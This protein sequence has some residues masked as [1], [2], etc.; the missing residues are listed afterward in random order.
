MTRSVRELAR[1]VFVA[2]R[3][4]CR[5]LQSRNHPTDTAQEDQYASVSG[6][7]LESQPHEYTLANSSP[8]ML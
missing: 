4:V 6:S 8:A 7:V 5:G 3:R 2:D 1:A